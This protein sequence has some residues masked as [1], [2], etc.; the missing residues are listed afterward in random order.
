MDLF[1]KRE[2]CVFDAAEVEFLGTIIREGSLGMDPVKLDGIRAWPVPT[3]VKQVQSFLGFCNFYRRFIR[4]YSKIAR[5]LTQLTRKDLPFQWTPE[6]QVAFDTLR[7]LFQQKPILCMADP[8]AAFQIECDASMFATG[9]VLRQ[10]NANQDWMPVAYLS[11]ALSPAER[12]YQIYDKELLAVVRAFETWQHYLEGSPHVIQV[13][14]DHKNLTYWRSAQ[15][16]TR[17]QARWSAFLGQ[18]HFEIHHHAGKTLTQA[19]ALSRRPDHADGKHNNEDVV[20]LN[21]GVFIRAVT[22]DLL[23]R[24]KDATRKDTKVVQTS[25]RGRLTLVKPPPYGKPE[26]WKLD[27]GVAKYQGKIYIPPNEDL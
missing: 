14:S 17:R 6:C 24:I 18:F 20:V 7:N 1:L 8:S 16:L 21:D 10:R 11:R 23:L 27:D 12:N 3:T 25:G 4:D 13:I 19:D 22:D 5:P 9:A 15:K 26:D 2:K